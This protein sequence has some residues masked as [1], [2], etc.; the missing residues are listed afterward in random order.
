MAGTALASVG[1]NPLCLAGL[2]PASPLLG[3]VALLI[4]QDLC[5]SPRC[6]PGHKKQCSSIGAV[7]GVSHSVRLHPAS[8]LVQIQPQKSVFETRLSFGLCSKRAT[9]SLS[10]L[11]VF[12]LR[13]DGFLMMM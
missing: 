3:T 11:V 5:F 9:P 10:E 8:C 7:R 13:E 4:L 1:A 6:P 12:P 2:P